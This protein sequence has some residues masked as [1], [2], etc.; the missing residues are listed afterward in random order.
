MT[1]WGRLNSIMTTI[2]KIHQE[3]IDLLQIVGGKDF[4]VTQKDFSTPPDH[5]MGEIAFGC[6]ALTKTFK[7]DPKIIAGNL[8]GIINKQLKGL[9][10]FKFIEKVEAAGPYLNFYFKK[11]ILAKEVLSEIEKEKDNF[12]QSKSGQGKKVMV[13][14]VSPNTNKPLHLGHIRNAALGWSIYKILEAS[15]YKVV[16][17]IL[18]NDRGI[19]ICKSMLAFQKWGPEP[20]DKKLKGDFLVGKY[21]IMFGQ[22]VKEDPKLQ[23]EAQEMLRKWEAGDKKVVTLWKKMNKLALT[24]HE[25]TYKKL[26]VSFDKK[27]L[28]SDLYKHGKEIV[29]EGLEKGIFKE[30]DGAVMVELEKYGLPNKVLQRSDGTALYITQDL[31]LAQKKVKENKLDISIYV[32]GSEQDLQLKQVFK[33]LELLG[34]SWAKNCYH[35]S[36]GLVYLPEGKMKSREGKVV[37]A[38]N[39]IKELESLARK[40]LSGRYKKISKK[41]LESRALIIA[42]GAIKYYILQVD[43]KSNMHFDPKES[44]SFN[45][46]T[47]PY[48]QYTYARI[49]SILKKAKTKL[50]KKVDYNQLVELE[51]KNMIFSLARF[52]LIIEESAENYDPSALAKYL[53]EL[54]NDFNNYYHKYPILKSEAKTSQARLNLI[55]SVSL[56]LKK[57]LE[58]LG[59]EVLKEM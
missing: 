56:V 57:G 17:S 18:I 19:H 2:N 22:K 54:A 20:E 40:E 10:K 59:I 47:G 48:L 21:Y 39:L 11:E 32:V 14:Y 53:Y 44:L 15:G 28:E 55:N 38:D 4:V 3:I 52:S 25:E 46:R 50:P 37:D 13:E 24:G 7:K 9:K 36:H 23:D 27:Y 42:L 30:E 41:E 58:L 34:Y 49:N 45:G 31:Y 8:A 16:K 1:I 12:G 26:K 43:P 29:K 51:E 5:K 6:F 33:T 35:L